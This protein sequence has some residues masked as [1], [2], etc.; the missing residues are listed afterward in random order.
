LE[1]GGAEATVSAFQIGLRQ[2]DG[3]ELDMHYLPIAEAAVLK[4]LDDQVSL[5]GEQYQVTVWPDVLAV[6]LG[7]SD[8]DIRDGVEL[9]ASIN[10]RRNG[11]TPL[12]YRLVSTVNIPTVV[13]DGQ[14]ETGSH[15]TSTVLDETDG[16]WHLR[17]F[18]DAEVTEADMP[19]DN[20]F[21]SEARMA[22]YV[23][24]TYL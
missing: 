9:P 13:R 5:F 20:D 1:E 10:V 2:R 15:Y 11:G 12:Q 19:V 3:L 8:D 22:F 21:V 24:T 17:I 14:R 16:A 7:D 6:A 23:Q 18:D 4:D